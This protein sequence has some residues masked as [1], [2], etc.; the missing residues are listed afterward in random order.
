MQLKR[1]KFVAEKSKDNR[2]I[3]NSSQ[4][5]PGHG[6]I[7]IWAELYTLQSPSQSMFIFIKS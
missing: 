2:W 4:L 5:L 1:K 3:V 7:R 6:G